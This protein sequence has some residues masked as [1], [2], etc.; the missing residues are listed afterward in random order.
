MKKF[1]LLVEEQM[2]TMEQL[3]FLQSELERCEEIEVQLM[4]LQE[5]TELESVQYEI[6][7]MKDELKEI[8]QLFENQTEAVIASYQVRVP[9]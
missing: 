6:I 4:S 1:D 5:G 2:K 7:R 3:L 9:S 8:H